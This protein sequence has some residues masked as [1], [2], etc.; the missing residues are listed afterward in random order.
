MKKVVF[1]NKKIMK[2][3][4]YGLL[5]ML[6]LFI[7]LNEYLG[8]M[9]EIWNYSFAKHLSNGLFPYRDFN[10]ISTPF[11]IF[12]NSLFLKINSSLITYRILY[13]IYY[14]AI[15][16]LLDKIFDT[17]K[18]KTFLKF[19]IIS[20]FVFI[21]VKVCYLD[22]NFMQLLLI[23][24]LIYCHLKNKDYQNSKLN[25]IIALISGI[26]I[27]NKQ[28]T[29]LIIA[30]IH[31]I[32]V[33]LNK[34]Y[35]KKDISIKFLLRQIII[36]LLPLILFIIYLIITKSL[37]DFYDQA[38]LGLTTF[39]N[40]YISKVFLFFTIIIYI[41]MIIGM[42]LN[43]NKLELWI[44]LLYCIASLS[45]I[46][47]IFD[48][49]HSSFCVALSFIFLTYIINN[50]I[51]KIND[52]Y[53]YILLPIL[54]ILLIY[55]IGSYITSPKIETG[56]YKYIKTRKEHQMII[57]NVDNFILSMPKDYDIYIL[58]PSASVFHLPLGIYHKYFDLFMKGN[59]GIKG[60]KEIL[61]I[62]NEDNKIFLI[63]EIN[64]NWQSPTKIVDYVKEKYSSCGNID[65]LTVYCHKK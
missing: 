49:V 51:N 14:I 19:I 21:L 39:T 28:S 25:I 35:F 53:T 31:I 60:Q 43:K 1:S 24:L 27:I 30:P 64:E 47:P 40:K 44:I 52:S 45:F 23:L 38:I 58:D 3:I 7:I 29:G 41:L 12:I 54:L 61:N 55:N 4:Y 65:F 26:T 50:K 5:S 33:M 8:N 6:L 22:Y 46:I 9:D 32:I 20:L 42:Y 16:F 56:I 34:F 63:N 48:N 17:L 15:I 2:I 11:S 37:Y 36:T 59:L 10:V 62:I 13:A 18:I 57:N